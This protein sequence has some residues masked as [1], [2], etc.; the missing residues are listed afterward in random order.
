MKAWWQ[1]LNLREQRLVMAMSAVIAVFVLYGLIW[2]PLNES[3]AASK[4]KLERQQTLLAWVEENTQRYQQAKRNG[5]MN[6]S[7]AS[8]SSIVNRT[9]R[10]NDITITR[11]QPQGDDLQVWIDEIS[12]NQ[13]LS[14]LEQL[15]SRENLQVK[16]IDLS[17]A[18]QEGVVR[19]R[20]LQ[21]GK[22]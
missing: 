11:M 14:W 21:L 12:F 4:L 19:V 18:D 3:I 1:Q 8:L 17:S 10:A 13:L 9:S 2:Q 5:A 7:S 15:A 16:N 20:R 22:S 6:S